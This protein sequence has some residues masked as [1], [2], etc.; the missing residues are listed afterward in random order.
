MDDGPALALREALVATL[1]ADVVVSELVAGRVYDEPPQNV[2]CPYV[3]IGNIDPRPQRD[4]CNGG[5]SVMVSVE[6]HSR[7]VAGRVEA[8]RIAEAIVAA[9][10]ENESAITLVGFT[11]EW[12]FLQ[13]QTVS[14]QADGR[15]YAAVVAFE[16]SLSA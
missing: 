15:S 6:A 8:T 7:P 5:W 1:T 12:M 2:A 4:S 11:L 3:R 9:L 13:T 16:A 14:R 10:N